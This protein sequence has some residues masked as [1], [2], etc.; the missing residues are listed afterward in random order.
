L[1]ILKYTAG[2]IVAA[3]TMIV[4]SAFVPH[5]EVAIGK[6]RADHLV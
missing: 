5:A 2:A 1:S 6:V 3:G 4:V